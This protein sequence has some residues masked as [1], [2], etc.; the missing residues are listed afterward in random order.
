MGTSNTETLNVSPPFVPSSPKLAE[1][2][3][4]RDESAGNLLIATRALTT[5]ASYGGGVEP[6]DSIEYDSTQDEPSS[7]MVARVAL[8]DIAN[9]LDTPMGKKEGV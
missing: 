9:P 8:R 4:E 7:A 2:V 6:D 3:A 1:A 5:I